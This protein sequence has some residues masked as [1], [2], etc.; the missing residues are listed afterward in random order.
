MVEQI[1]SLIK[2]KQYSKA[3]ECL[4]TLEP[5]QLS[6]IEEELAKQSK[7][8]LNDVI[9]NYLN[10]TNSISKELVVFLCIYFEDTLIQVIRTS[11]YFLKC[12]DEQFKYLELA[13]LSTQETYQKHLRVW[14]HFRREE[15]KLWQAIEMEMPKV[16]SLDIADVL[17]NVIHSFESIRFH[18]DSSEQEFDIYANYY[19]LFIEL[20]LSRSNK[21]L[22]DTKSVL[23][24]NEKEQYNNP[25]DKIFETIKQRDTFLSGIVDVYSF[26]KTS[27][28]KEE[29][30]QLYLNQSAKD[31]YQWKLDGYRYKHCKASYILANSINNKFD[32]SKGKEKID[33]V[34][35]TD[36]R[37][38]Q[39][40]IQNIFQDLCLSDSETFEKENLFKKIYIG[41]L[42]YTRNRF[43]RYQCFL[44]ELRHNHN[45]WYEAYKEIFKVNGQ[46]FRTYS[47]HMNIG[48]EK[49]LDFI[50]SMLDYAN[51]NYQIYP[52]ILYS[53]NDLFYFT[54]Y[55]LNSYKGDEN[56]IIEEMFNELTYT[57]KKKTFN[58]FRVT[59]NVY[60]S[61]FISVGEDIYFCPQMFLANMDFF[62]P[63]IN[64]AIRHNDKSRNRREACRRQEKYLAEIFEEKGYTVNQPSKQEV[65]Q[66]KGDVDIFVEDGETS[67]FIQLKRPY[68]R[69][70]LEEQYAESIN[71]D[72]KAFKQ[73]N[74]AEK[75][76]LEHKKPWQVNHKPIKWLV[77]TSFERINQKVDSCNKINYF[78]LLFALRH[79]QKGTPLKKLIEFLEQDILLQAQYD[80]DLAILRTSTQE[81]IYKIS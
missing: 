7:Y 8:T 72:Q 78:D 39:E 66:M 71:P 44:D 62:Y 35:N 11:Q 55:A 12:S 76:I 59:Y 18:K 20:Y 3:L 34:I 40:S 4:K 56:M 48:G 58:R 26:D 74:D 30:G 57:P 63:G 19:N 5:K 80:T 75:Y 1:K 45:T 22:S 9:F 60:Q 54:S 38:F 51:F 67:L 65:D 37:I 21:K 47:P 29:K 64:R 69:T 32:T 79:S 61:P 23:M 81:F 77:S 70:T 52:Y 53:K 2:D 14:K 6:S 24:V 50:S 46:K 28:L 43:Y 33:D 27:K 36:V 16:L 15:Q 41:M 25:L 42:A 10:E 73:L 49:D 17:A 68:L 31:Y 13:E